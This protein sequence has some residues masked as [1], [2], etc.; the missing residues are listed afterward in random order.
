M[1]P[2]GFLKFYPHC[3]NILF[4]KLFPVAAGQNP[5]INQRLVPMP[6]EAPSLLENATLEDRKLRELQNKPYVDYTKA[7]QLAW[8]KIMA[9]FDDSIYSFLETM[10]DANENLDMR[11]L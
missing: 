6:E 2:R 4:A 9:S 11:I 3:D 5:P 8:H 1:T 10:A 7:M